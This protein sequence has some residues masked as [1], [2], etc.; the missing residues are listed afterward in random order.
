MGEYT[1]VQKY[2][3]III[4][5]YIANIP[6]EDIHRV[7]QLCIYLDYSRCNKGVCFQ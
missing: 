5:A 2:I 3:R 6:N 7:N 4:E 1:H